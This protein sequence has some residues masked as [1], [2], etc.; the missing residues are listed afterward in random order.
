MKCYPSYLLV[1]PDMRAALAAILCKVWR[2]GKS[3][4]IAI[5]A[6]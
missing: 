5:A 6:P 2:N 3:G 4:Y 1:A